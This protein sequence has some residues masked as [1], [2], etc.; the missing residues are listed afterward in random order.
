MLAG[1]INL[2]KQVRLYSS[3]SLKALNQLF[4]STYWEELLSVMFTANDKCDK[5]AHTL[6]KA[7]DKLVSLR[8]VKAYEKPNF[9]A[10]LKKTYFRTKK[11]IQETQTKSFFA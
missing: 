11:F 7:V 10:Y 4:F 1:D 8:T 6:T 9:P 2:R 3:G 5:F